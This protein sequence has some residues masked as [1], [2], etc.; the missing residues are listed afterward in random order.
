MS[1]ADYTRP[2]CASHLSKHFPFDIM[3]PAHLAFD[4]GA[5]SGRAIMG[6]LDQSAKK[7]LRLVEVHRFEHQSIPTPTGPVWDVTGIWQHLLA[8]LSAA[9]VWCRNNGT[10]LNSV[11]VDAWGV[12]WVLL[13]KSG[14]LLGLPHCYRDPQNEVACR[15]VLEKLGGF[16]RLFERTGIQ[17][18][19]FNTIFQLAARH[20]QEPQLFAAAHRLAFLPDLFHFWLSGEMATERTMASTSSLLNVKTGDWDEGLMHELGLPAN[21][22]GPIIDPGTVLGTLRTEIANATGAAASVRVI[23]PA[24]HDTASAVA[25]VPAIDG[26]NWAYLSSGTWSLLGAELKEPIVSAA[27]RS[28]PFTNERGMD[29][30]IR[31]LKN[32]AGLWPLQELRRE[33]QQQGDQRGFGE[34]VAEARLAEPRRTLVDL[35]QPEFALPGNMVEK[36]KTQAR[37]AGQ[38]EPES[39]GQLVR[40]CLE[41]LAS[42]YRTTLDQLES[43][44][45]QSF[46]V[47]YIVGGG[48]QNTL[49]N[50]LT[51]EAVGR[52]VI[53]GPVEATAIG[54]LLIQAVGCGELAGLGELRQ[55]VADSFPWHCETN[56]GETVAPC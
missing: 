52:P 37:K 42:C 8:G 45:G 44:T 15:R 22:L 29:G 46:Q 41:S 40:C 6:V 1:T 12:D 33:F 50:E 30:T 5:S 3:P 28:I 18:L 38:L 48:T 43:V 13:G 9:T 24:E 16:E 39:V 55:V 17:L 20:Q 27:A 10:E 23:A 21:I 2:F 36:F 35:N 56:N 47:L 32:I 11:G 49:L 14:E 51:E 19:D 4:L 26:A 31:F 7:K 54:N 34:L 53:V 25:A